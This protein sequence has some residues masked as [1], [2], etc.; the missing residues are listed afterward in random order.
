[1]ISDAHNHLQDSQFEPHLEVVLA[2]CAREGVTAMVVNGSCEADWASVAELAGKHPWIRPAFGLHPWDVRQRAKGWRDRLLSFLDRTPN[3]SVGEIGIDSWILDRVKPGDPRIPPGGAASLEEQSEVFVDQLRIAADR[4]LPASIH[5]L[6]AF[7]PL[8]R[9]LESEPLPKCGFLLHAYSGP[10]EMVPCF[11]RLGA[12]FSFNGAFL[13][14]RKQR[15]RDLYASIPIDRLLVESDAPAMM[16]PPE[17]MASELPQSPDGEE[18]NNP[19][20]TARFVAPL[21][22]LRGIAPMVLADR[23]EA[24][25]RT[26]FGG[27]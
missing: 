13:H 25:F 10:I 4:N 19:A 12:Y 3:A 22:A 21:A 6:D 7:G 5:C 9:I 2:D 1:M 15:I 16:P 23:L 17:F 24:N 18:I 11:V 27:T 8:L 26:L 14:P 20:S